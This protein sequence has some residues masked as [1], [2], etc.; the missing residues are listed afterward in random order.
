[1]Q[2]IANHG[3]KI[4]LHIHSAKSSKKDGKKVKNNTISSIPVLAQKLN[5]QGVNICS[6]TDHDTFSYAMY[7]ALKQE[8][9]NN[10]SI[11][12]VLPGVEFTV[13]FTT[14]ERESI[15]HV[16]AIFSDEEEDKVQRI[17]SIIEQNPPNYN[18]SYQEEDFLA[19]LRQIDI[20]TILI[21]HQKNTLSSAKTKK[22]DVNSVGER[23]FL[24]FVYTDYFEALEFK[25]RRNEVINKNYLME[26]QLEGKVRFVT[27]TDCHDWSVYPAETP[28]D[29]I[30]DFPYTYAK[31][32]PTFKGLVMAITDHNRLKSVDSFFTATQYTLPSINFT[33]NIESKCVQRGCLHFQR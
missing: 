28:Q 19:L 2:K 31:C 20:N 4:D 5:E 30:T 1:M 27:G 10:N 15:V 29:T 24:E 33:H 7:K 22:N 21:A 25:N 18:Q 17:E 11:Q 14:E 32:L 26:N 6:I 3:L 13:C 12:K 16:V 8:E 9:V 23:K